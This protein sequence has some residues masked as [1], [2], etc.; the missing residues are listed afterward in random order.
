MAASMSDVQIG[1][2]WTKV[3]V[4]AMIS[5]GRIGRLV[6]CH[7]RKRGYDWLE[8]WRTAGIPGSECACASQNA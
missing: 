8:R 6:P 3:I 2:L 4:E 7:R 5:D 1:R